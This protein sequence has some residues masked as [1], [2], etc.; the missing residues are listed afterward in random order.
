MSEIQK[1]RTDLE[2]V[3][4]LMAISEADFQLLENKVTDL[5]TSLGDLTTQVTDLATALTNE[6]TART[7]GDSNLNQTI[8]AL[9]SRMKEMEDSHILMAKNELNLDE[10]DEDPNTAGIQ[11]SKDINLPITDKYGTLITWMSNG[12]HI[13]DYG[14]VARPTYTDGNVTESITAVLM[15]GEAEASKTFDIEILAFPATDLEKVAEDIAALNLDFVTQPVSSDIALPITGSV[16]ALDIVWSSDNEAVIGADGSVTQP[17]YYD[18]NTDVTLTATITSGA[19][20]D[21]V[22]FIITV[23][24]LP[25]SDQQKVDED[26]S[27]L[28][29]DGFDED[30]GTAGTQVSMDMTLP[31]LGST[32]GSDIAWSSN[33]VAHLDDTGLVTRPA[34]GEPDATVILTANVTQGAGTA[35]ADYTVI[36]LAETVDPSA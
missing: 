30:P 16:H 11:V 26:L 29:L 22:N 24:A 5:E 6:S 21:T 19:V 10:L 34:F 15:Y 8:L 3:K 18:G 36:V 4:L 25:I 35:S 14:V 13:S 31:V 17:D 9:T 1:L 33:D 28:T 20:S 23:E 7:D 12:V 2:E 32:H 27:F